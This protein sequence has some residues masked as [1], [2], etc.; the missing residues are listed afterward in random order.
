MIA[1]P[2]PPPP[3]VK[4]QFCR[5]TWL[6]GCP[7]LM[8]ESGFYGSHVFLSQNKHDQ[9]HHESCSTLC[10]SMKSNSAL[11]YLELQKKMNIEKA[12][13]QKAGTGEKVSDVENLVPNT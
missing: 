4:W 6:A 2:P 13:R 11:L 12:S 7:Y 8:Q 1:T 3:P 9:N 10:T 5:Y